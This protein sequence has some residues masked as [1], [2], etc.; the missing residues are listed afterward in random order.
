MD[1]E[2]ETYAN[3]VCKLLSAVFWSENLVEDGAVGVTPF[4]VLINGTPN[5]LWS[6][7]LVLVRVLNWFTIFPAFLELLFAFPLNVGLRNGKCDVHTTGDC[8]YWL[9]SFERNH[10][11][12][13]QLLVFITLIIASALFMEAGKA[14]DVRTFC[15]LN[16]FHLF[17]SNCHFSYSLARDF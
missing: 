8:V 7:L 3:F 13:Y 4:A 2:E 15:V 12:V 1:W 11:I 16:Q 14:L 10:T 5:N 6:E 17:G 9:R